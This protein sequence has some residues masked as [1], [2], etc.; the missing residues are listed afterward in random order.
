MG[1]EYDSPGSGGRSAPLAPVSQAALVRATHPTAAHWSAVSHPGKEHLLGGDVNHNAC[2]HQP[3]PFP[4]RRLVVPPGPFPPFLTLQYCQ[5]GFVA[6]KSRVCSC[7]ARSST[8][9]R[10]EPQLSYCCGCLRSWSMPFWMAKIT[11]QTSAKISA[12]AQKCTV[13]THRSLR[14]DAPNI[15]LFKSPRLAGVIVGCSARRDPLRP[16][17]QPAREPAARPG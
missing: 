16:R 8:Q 10:G 15:I 14:D 9:N 3:R 17:V 4:P 1:F 5:H 12:L 6:T 2:R 7:G 11:E 13:D